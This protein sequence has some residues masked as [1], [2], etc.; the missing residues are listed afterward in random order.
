MSVDLEDADSHAVG[1]ADTGSNEQDVAEPGIGTVPIGTQ[2][3]Y[4]AKV[5]SLRIYVLAVHQLVQVTAASGA[6]CPIL[7]EDVVP[8]VGLQ[9]VVGGK[10]GHRVAGVLLKVSTGVKHLSAESR[11]GDPAAA[12]GDDLAQSIDRGAYGDRCVHFDVDGR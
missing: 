10:V 7:D 4:A 2:S 9:D 1:A 5:D 8:V 6:Q 12:D 11:A 3:R